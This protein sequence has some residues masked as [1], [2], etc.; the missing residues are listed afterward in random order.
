MNHLQRNNHWLIRDALKK[1]QLL[2]SISVSDGG[3]IETVSLE[4]EDYW[5]DC[6]PLMGELQC[7]KTAWALFIKNNG[8]SIDQHADYVRAYFKLLHVGL[9]C[10]CH[11]EIDL[12][13][14][15]RI[16]AFETFQVC[17]E[18]GPLA[19][20]IF[21]VRNPAYL[22]SRL[23]YP[24][25]PDN[26]KYLPLLCPLDHALET[27]QLYGHYR[28]IPIQGTKGIQLFVYP[29]IK[30]RDQPLSH[31]LIG[32]LFASLT[33][34]TDPWVHERSQFLFHGVFAALVEQLA[35]T[36][37]QLLDIACGSAKTT[38]SLCRKAFSAFRKSFDL[39]LVDVVRGRKSIA[40][41]FYHNPSIFGNIIFRRE[42]LFDWMEKKD[43]AAPAHFDIVLMLRICD[44][45]SR[46]HIET[47]PFR[48]A[49]RML[50][51]KENDCPLEADVLRPGKLIE[52]KRFDKI[53]HSIKRLTIQGGTAFRQFSLS[54]Y[55]KAIYAVIGGKI[56]GENDMIY[57]PIRR[58]DSNALV[59]PSGQS[60]IAR[61][62][63]MADCIVIE[64]ADLSPGRLQRHF[65]HFGLHDLRITDMTRLAKMRGASVYIV[66]KKT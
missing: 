27:G 24:R 56:I 59:L 15:W 14:L 64:D 45:F 55:F 18:Q 23:S 62:M 21:N 35:S 31:S 1:T 36:R 44:V 38:M 17:G 9:N 40:T 5:D 37:I 12:R 51:R 42:S 28:R 33:P 20:G 22:L 47:I 61:L 46:F 30:S 53:D 60:L 4:W 34:K 50:R 49:S 11:G 19:A 41:T 10:F 57:L 48:E 54:D 25:A 63:T 58:L 29:L 13:S 26:P 66:D 52:D 3:T 16:V 39:T 65:D 32:R 6:H 2:A 8:Y 43:H 7:L